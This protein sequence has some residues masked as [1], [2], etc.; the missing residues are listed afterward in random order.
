MKRLIVSIVLL[1]IISTY[2]LSCEK[3]DICVTPTTPSIVIEFYQKDS[4][5]LP[6]NVDVK[7]YVLGSTKTD[8]IT[9]KATMKLP[10][11]VDAN[12]TQ[13]YLT[14]KQITGAGTFMNTD[15]LEFNYQT[16]NTYVSRACGF[17]T[18]FTLDPDTEEKNAIDIPGPGKD[19]LWIPVS[20]FD[21]L[22][23]NIEDENEAHIKIY[24]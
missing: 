1:L 21:V 4:P 9:N 12:T 5:T 7:F 14:Y 23:Y 20:G 6:K 18:T 2:L 24:L 17:K 8:S 10:L 13:W 22:K 3:D 11:K 15:I 16:K 19:G